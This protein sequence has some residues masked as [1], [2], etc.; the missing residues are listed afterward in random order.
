[1][2]RKSRERMQFFHRHRTPASPH[3]T[4]IACNSWFL[5]AWRARYPQCCCSASP[6]AR[7]PSSSRPRARLLGGSRPGRLPWS[8]LLSGLGSETGP[9]HCSTA[10]SAES[11]ASPLLRRRPL[12]RPHHRPSSRLKPVHH[13]WH[14]LRRRLRRQIHRQRLRP[15][16]RR[17]PARHPWRRRRLRRQ[18]HHHRHRH[19]RRPHPPSR[20]QTTAWKRRR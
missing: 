14:H 20:S 16:S 6:A 3:E 9:V 11:Q 1:M 15:S 12:P 4:R 13:R 5:C 19:R 2:P 17:R 10:C 18:R 8:P 7:L